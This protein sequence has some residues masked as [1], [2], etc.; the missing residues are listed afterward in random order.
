[1]SNTAFIESVSEDPVERA[2]ARRVVRILN[3]NSLTRK[4]RVQLVRSA[5]RDLLQHRKDKADKAALAQQVAEQVARAQLPKGFIPKSAQ[6]VAGRLQIGGVMR[7]GPTAARSY[8]WIE[9]GQPGEAANTGA[10]TK[11]YAL[12]RAGSGQNRVRK[13]LN[14][15]I[16]ERRLALAA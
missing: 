12:N 15:A 6:A 9:A 10:N 3:D 13:D 16:A 5:Q 4:Q 1:M 7:S 2:I 11:V 8:V 14:A